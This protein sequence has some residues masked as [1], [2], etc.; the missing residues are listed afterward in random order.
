MAW[1]GD[2][3]RVWDKWHVEDMEEVARKIGG[4]DVS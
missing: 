1:G 3:F 4:C 2:L